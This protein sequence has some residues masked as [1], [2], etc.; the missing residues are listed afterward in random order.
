MTSIKTFKIDQKI[1]NVLSSNEKKILPILAKA[2]KKIDEIFLLQ[3]NENYK[4]AN[5]YPHDAERSEI[6]DA[7]KDDPKILSPFTVVERDTD[8]KLI[9]IDY[10][11]KY[12]KQLIPAAQLLKDAVKICQNRSL[13]N[14]LEVLSKSLLDGTYQKA[15]IAWLAV[16]GTNISL[17]IGPYERYLDKLFFIKRA[18]QANIGIIDDEQTQKAKLIRDILATTFGQ[19]PHMVISPSAVDMQVIHCIVVSGFLG[20]AVFREQ[21][22]PCDTETTERYGSRILGYVS[23]IDYKFEKLIY[24]IFRT[25]FE[26][27]FQAGYS[28][29]LLRQGNYY[30]VLLT[31]IARQLHRYR[32]SRTRLKNLFPILDEANC[33]VSGV[34]HGKHLILKG[35]ISQ[36]ELEAIM[37][38][39]ICWMFSE[40]IISKKTKIR[41]D[42][43]KGDALTFNF[44]VDAGALQEKEGISW[45][46][47]AKMFFEMESLATI[48]SRILDEGS[49]IDAQEFLSKYLS[50]ES[51]KV[52]DTRLSKIK[53]L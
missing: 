36:K 42:Y 16:K 38:L 10:H 46:N 21:H 19:R 45:P 40:W 44:L 25:I 49:Y 28:K 20:R 13:K 37:I 18:Y 34:H 9:T 8:E 33:I 5:L 11:L 43:L 29:D 12:G 50:L 22:L 39:V 52:F 24:P 53:P 47:F 48:F 4:G 7:A 51:F 17:N 41:E 27:K 23:M 1:L 14:Y 3:E 30:F 31:A 35:V 32:G 26:K 6:E 15:D 2:V